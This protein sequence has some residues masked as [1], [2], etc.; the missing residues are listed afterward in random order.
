MVTIPVEIPSEAIAAFCQ[1][2]HIR[3]LSLFGS[4]LTDRFR[5]D[6]DVDLLV[7]FE[8]G[9]GPGYFGL[10]G[11]EM[12][13]SE[14]IGRKVDLRTPGELSRHFREEVVASAVPQYE[15]G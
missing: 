1:R 7:E 13:L 15:Q 8:K 14:M 9:L 11:M 10:V 5:D 4:I 6:S 12:E 2:N 3:K